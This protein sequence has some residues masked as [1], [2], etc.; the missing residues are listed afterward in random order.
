[1][2]C[3]PIEHHEPRSIRC[4]CQNPSDPEPADLDEPTPLELD[5]PWDIFLPDDGHDP[6]PEPGDFWI[7]FNQLQQGVL[8]A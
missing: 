8:A 4:L 2:T 6:L 3:L 5:D 1:M 7:E